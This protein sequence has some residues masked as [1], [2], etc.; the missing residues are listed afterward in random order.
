VQA[1]F[2]GELSAPGGEGRGE[3]HSPEQF[4][5]QIQTYHIKQQ[6]RPHSP[7]CTNTVLALWLLPFILSPTDHLL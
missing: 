6:I 7:I 1:L 3:G 5:T 4:T 2:C